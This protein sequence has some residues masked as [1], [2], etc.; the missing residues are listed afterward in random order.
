MTTTMNTGLDELLDIIHEPHPSLAEASIEDVL[1][2]LT[3]V[4]DAILEGWYTS[5]EEL[6]LRAR[7]SKL[8]ARGLKRETLKTLRATQSNKGIMKLAV[9]INHQ[10]VVKLGENA[11]LEAEVY[12]EVGNKMRAKLVPTVPL[13][14]LGCLQLKVTIPDSFT[15]WHFDNKEIEKQYSRMTHDNNDVHRGN[16]GIWKDRLLHLDFAGG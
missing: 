3:I 7:N 4:A 12:A 1:A 5:L 11:I 6:A 15:G 10:W 2:Y 16:V 9:F 14:D 8:D 13:G